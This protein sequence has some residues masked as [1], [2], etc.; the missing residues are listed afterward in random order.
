VDGDRLQ[1]AAGVDV[2]RKRKLN[3][4]AMDVSGRVQRAHFRPD[5][6]FAARRRELAHFGVYAGLRACTDLVADVDTGS[7]V[8]AD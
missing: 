2:T 7:G 3:D 4:D 8:V 5:R 6:P 1:D